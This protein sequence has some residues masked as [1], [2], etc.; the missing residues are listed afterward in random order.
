MLSLFSCSFRNYG[1]VF[2]EKASNLS[3]INTQSA[4]NCEVFYINLHANLT[5]FSCENV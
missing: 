3:Q 2:M 5:D 1:V 4:S